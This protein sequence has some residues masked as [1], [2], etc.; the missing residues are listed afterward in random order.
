MLWKLLSWHFQ[1]NNSVFNRF[2]SILYVYAQL[3]GVRQNCGVIRTWTFA[4]HMLN[5]LKQKQFTKFQM[6]GQFGLKSLEI[7]RS[8]KSIILWKNFKCNINTNIYMKLTQKI[9]SR[10]FINIYFKIIDFSLRSG[11]SNRTHKNLFLDEKSILKLMVTIFINKKLAWKFV[12]L[13]PFSFDK[14][15][16]SFIRI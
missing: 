9:F 6:F 12:I 15:D 10:V 8:H 14:Y 2:C 16:K 1:K 11:F 5:T 13:F 3:A 4:R 7:L